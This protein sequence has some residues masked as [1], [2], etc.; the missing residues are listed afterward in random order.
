M[1][2]DQNQNN[3]RASAFTRNSGLEELLQ[4]INSS[5]WVSEKRFIDNYESPNLP[6]VLIMG[7]MRSGT[8]LFMQW[9]ANSGLFAYP[10]N[11]LSRFYHAPIIGAKIQL[12]LTDPRYSFRDELGDFQQSSDYQSENGKT[13]GALAPNEFW[14]FWRRFLPESDRDV[15]TDDE[16]RKGLDREAMLAELSG[17]IDV[18]QKPLAAKAMLFNY[19]IPYL[20]SIFEKALFVQIQR[21]PVSNVAS[22]IDARKKQFGSV[23]KWYSFQI[24]EYE[25]IKNLDPVSQVAAQVH[26]MNRA[27]S[28]GIATVDASRRIVVRYEELCANPRKVFEELSTKVGIDG[29]KYHGPEHFDVTRLTDNANRSAI[30]KAVLRFSGNSD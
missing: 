2:E 30:E 24:P 11:L 22:V 14:Y 17:V 29:G 12:L 9:L 28:Q 1:N 6:V 15:W 20:D 26:Y 3:R 19:N 25:E 13:R 23:D 27:V 10:T 21:D 18:F 4:D 7:P 16:L 8:T 5:L